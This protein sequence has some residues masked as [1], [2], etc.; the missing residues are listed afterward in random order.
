MDYLGALLIVLAVGYVTGKQLLLA[1]VA[2]YTLN[3]G[4]QPVQIA[5]SSVVVI[6]LELLFG[7]F[8][9]AK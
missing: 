7:I 9:R 2:L 5:L 4:F 1:V 6:I 3:A 8:E